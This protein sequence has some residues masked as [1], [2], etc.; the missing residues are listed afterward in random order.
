MSI[1]RIERIRLGAGTLLTGIFSEF[2]AGSA[3]PLNTDGAD[4]DVYIQ[5][6]AGNSN[7]WIKRLGA[8]VALIGVALNA[9]LTDNATTTV[10]SIPAAAARYLSLDYGL[11]RTSA[12]QRTGK[13]DMSTDGA[14][15][16][17]SDFGMAIIGTDGVT[18]DAA[19]SGANVQLQA[20]L[21]STGNN[22]TLTYFLRNWT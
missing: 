4:G 12:G 21:T 9:T 7:I 16:V 3:A 22:A 17:V 6:A 2:S 11:Q 19:I 1:Q 20:T 8:W 18:F 5:V 15:A 13:L 14:S 10:F